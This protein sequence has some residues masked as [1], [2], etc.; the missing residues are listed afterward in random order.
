MEFNYD[1]LT[2][3][4]KLELFKKLQQE[5]I[6]YIDNRQSKREVVNAAWYKLTGHVCGKRVGSMITDLVDYMTANYKPG[7]HGTPIKIKDVPSDKEK[8]Y[9]EMST[10]ICKAIYK[11][12]KSAD[13]MWAKIKES[14]LAVDANKKMDT[15]EEKKIGKCR[16]CKWNDNG[17]C[18]NPNSG[19]NGTKINYEGF[20]M[21]WERGHFQ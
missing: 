16:M 14:Q 8:A 11:Y 13:D 2:Y 18:R 17:F 20:C 4:Q 21:K 6:G 12:E 1:A 3:E 15:N 19:F 7:N 10:A 9:V 5:R